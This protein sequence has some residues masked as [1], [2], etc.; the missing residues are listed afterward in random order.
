MMRGELTETLT[1]LKWLK[2][3]FEPTFK[4][5]NSECNKNYHK[6]FFILSLP[7]LI[8]RNWT[9]FGSFQTFCENILNDLFFKKKTLKKTPAAIMNGNSIFSIWRLLSEISPLSL[10]LARNK[11]VEKTED[12]HQEVFSKQTA[13]KWT[14]L[15]ILSSDILHRNTHIHWYGKHKPCKYIFALALKRSN[16][17]DIC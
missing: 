3:R 9:E 11:V 12:F 7:W 13:L 14:L 17:L 6:L 5:I 2:N 4:V 16:N 8:S 10:S 1:V 15:C